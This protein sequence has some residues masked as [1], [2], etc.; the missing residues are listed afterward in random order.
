MTG[1]SEESQHT[2]NLK[3]EGYIVVIAKSACNYNKL[4]ML[5]K[6]TSDSATVDLYQ[7]ITV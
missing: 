4:E 1:V 6:A 5:I 3:Y 2:C 7:K